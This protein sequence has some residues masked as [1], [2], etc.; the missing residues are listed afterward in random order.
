MFER[1]PV[2]VIKKLHEVMKRIDRVPKNG[3][4]SFHGYEYVTETDLV[5]KLRGIL[6][7]VGLF[8]R[9]T[10]LEVAKEMDLSRVKAQFDVIDVETGEYIS[11]VFWGEGQDKGDKGFY[12]AYTG[13]E[14]YFLMKTFLIPTGDDPEDDSKQPEAGTIP[15]SATKKATKKEKP[16]PKEEP[17]KK[18]FELSLLEQERVQKGLED[19]AEKIAEITSEGVIDVIDNTVHEL[20]G[21]LKLYDLTKDEARDVYQQLVKKLN[22]LKKAKN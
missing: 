3:Y 21:D 5:E 15:A 14:K 19:I 12:K 16:E 2:N 9:T 13:A 22:N 1:Y 6:A 8:V 11:E 7:D 18:L 10:I 20:Y 17:A 4:N